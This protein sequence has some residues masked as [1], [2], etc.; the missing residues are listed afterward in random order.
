MKKILFILLIFSSLLSTG[1]M[2]AARK[3]LLSSGFDLIYKTESTTLSQITA[4]FRVIQFRPDGLKMYASE[5]NGNTFQYSL[6]TAWDVSTASYDNVV[7]NPSESFQNT[8]AAFSE[9]GYNIYLTDNPS[10]LIRQYTLST[11][12]DLST[13]SNSMTYSKSTVLTYIKLQIVDNGNY[14]LMSIL[15]SPHTIYKYSFGTPNNISTLNLTP[16]DSY[17]TYGYFSIT[18]LGN[19]LYVANG[20]FSSIYQYST[21]AFT[22]SS[23]FNEE[24]DIVDGTT[25]D[26]PNYLTV[27]NGNGYL[28]ILDSQ[29]KK[30]VQYIINR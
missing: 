2:S 9:D 28:Y 13:A 15:F 1:Q 11:A 17:N 4:T 30:I 7:H 29:N 25:I 16:V 3:L 10:Q 18:D 21:S 22:P 20:N 14:A 6:S 19:Y 23:S 26:N 8:S 12:W 5:N 24:S 27:Q